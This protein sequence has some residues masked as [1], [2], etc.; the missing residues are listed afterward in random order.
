MNPICTHI[1]DR[2]IEQQLDGHAGPDDAA[3]QAHLQTCALCRQFQDQLRR[4]HERLAQ[5][6][7]SVEPLVT[8]LH[9]RVAQRLRSAQQRHQGLRRLARPMTFSL[10]AGVLIVAG[11]WVALH[12]R[13]TPSVAIQDRRPIAAEPA[14][15]PIGKTV[16]SQMDQEMTQAKTLFAA[17][18]INRL[19]NLLE[20]GLSSTQALVAGHLA[21][22]N[23]S[24]ASPVLQRLAAMRIR[25]P[26]L[27]NEWRHLARNRTA[28]R[29]DR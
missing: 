11:L 19:M 5:Y 13:Q 18:D 10:A 4:D 20:T 6:A 15:P 8:G 14:P 1:R 28:H 26:R 21:E 29:L 22:L 24:Q 3:V 17:H 23:A 2:L 27:W 9:D 25:L 7:R 12:G 16:P